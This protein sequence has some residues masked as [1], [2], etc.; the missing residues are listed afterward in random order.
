MQDQMRTAGG[1]WRFPTL[2]NES[3]L[4]LAEDSSGSGYSVGNTLDNS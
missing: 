4:T 3:C 2:I 1:R